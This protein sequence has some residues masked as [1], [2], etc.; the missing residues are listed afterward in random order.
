MFDEI[1]AEIVNLSSL[2]LEDAEL[3]YLASQDDIKPA[4]IDFL[5]NFRLHP[6]KELYVGMKGKELDIHTNR[7]A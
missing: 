2:Y 6:E 5:Q 3:D 1:N 7:L 4:Y